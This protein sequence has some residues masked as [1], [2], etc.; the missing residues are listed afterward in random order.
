ML[1]NCPI[2]VY[3]QVLYDFALDIIHN[4]PRQADLIVTLKHMRQPTITMGSTCSN[5]GFSTADD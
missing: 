5:E 3:M 2:S 4:G 1:V